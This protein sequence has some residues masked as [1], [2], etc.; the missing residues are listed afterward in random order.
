MTW[1]VKALFTKPDDFSFILGPTRWKEII[2]D[3]KLSS[4]HSPPPT[5]IHT[6]CE[7]YENTLNIFYLVNTI[8]SQ[9][10]TALRHDL[11]HSSEGCGW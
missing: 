2:D 6:I 5:D 9:Q 8:A 3:N 1:Y 11:A 7:K 4:D 10:Q